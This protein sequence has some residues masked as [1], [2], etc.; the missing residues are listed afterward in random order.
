[1]MAARVQALVDPRV[2][3]RVA[4]SDIPNL[5]AVN[6]DSQQL[7]ALYRNGSSA[8]EAS[9]HEPVLRSVRD[10]SALRGRP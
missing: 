6:I 2:A 3:T 9:G 5:A 1:M 8:A 7:S 4:P 10:L